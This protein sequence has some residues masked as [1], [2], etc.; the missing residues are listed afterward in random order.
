VV[1]LGG[2]HGEDDTVQHDRVLDD[3]WTL[4]APGKYYHQQHADPHF[5]VDPPRSY[6]RPQPRLGG[7]GRARPRAAT[8]ALVLHRR[9]LGMGQ[10]NGPWYVEAFE[11]ENPGR[12]WRA[13][14][15]DAEWADWDRNG[16]LLF[17]R[18][19]C[20]FRVPALRID[21]GFS[22]AALLADF[23]DRTFRNLR[24]PPEA[25]RW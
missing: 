3:G 21:P 16:D 23:R 20:L 11:V 13:P 19:G 25:T 10:V 7:D 1:P 6:A 17:A 14:I 22:A 12:G 15:D 5:L 18:Q 4:T 24:P 9:V 2:P 8:A